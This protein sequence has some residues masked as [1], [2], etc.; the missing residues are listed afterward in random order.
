MPVY[1]IKE[2]L[3]RIRVR[4]HRSNLPRAKGAYYARPA[5]E[6]ALSVE[7]VAAAM[8]NRGGF[9]G[10]YDDL[11]LHVRMFFQ[12]MAYQLCDG[13]AVNTGWFLVQPVIGGLFESPDE[14]FDPKK[15]RIGFRF[16]AGSRLRKLAE[17][18]E[19]I[20][21][22]AAHS[23]S[24]DCLTD[25][26][27]GLVNEAVTPGGLFIAEGRRIKVT[28]TSPDCGV[29]FVSQKDPDR[30][31]KVAKALAGNSSSKVVGIVPALPAGEYGL[32]IVTRYTI[33]GKEL[34]EP[35]TVKSAFT[36]NR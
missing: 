26:E 34:K 31:Y 27:S 35:K 10:S 9:T 20:M 25:L 23:G 29:W 17:N 36:V 22:T 30:R 32:E 11:V 19:V 2:V 4:L 14:G 18:A 28:G 15:H 24:I 33:G 5:N 1:D 8:K 3:H 21:E 12:E 13:Y 16:R 6:A 7:K